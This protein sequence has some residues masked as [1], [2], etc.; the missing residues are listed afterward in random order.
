[1]EKKQHKASFV[2][3]ILSISLFWLTWPGMVLGIIGLCLP[4]NEEKRA[5]DIALN[6]V[7][8]V[9]SFIWLCYIL[10]TMSTPSLYA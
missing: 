7:G 5:R 1:M 8:L 10:G 4:K 2:L 6:L 9:L 3:G